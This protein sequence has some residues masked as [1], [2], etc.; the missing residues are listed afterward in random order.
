MSIR[1]TFNG[2]EKQSEAATR[3]IEEMEAAA[4]PGEGESCPQQCMRHFQKLMAEKQK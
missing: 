2:K 4:V 3:P 1:K